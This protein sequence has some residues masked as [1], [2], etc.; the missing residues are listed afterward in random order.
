MC[1]APTRAPN[2]E[3]KIRSPMKKLFPLFSIA[4]LAAFATP[5]HARKTVKIDGSSSVF[6]ITEAV[7]EEF[8]KD[9]KG[10]VLV[11][12]G[13]SG[14]G[15]GFKKFCRG[16]ID[17]QDASRPIKI[18]EAAICKESNIS[19]IELPI[20]YDAITV[21]V[22]KKNTWLKDISMEELKKIWEPAAQGKVTT[23]NQVRKEWPKQPIRLYGA[24]S[25]SGTFDY[26][27][28]AV[29]GTARSSRSDYTSSE[30]DNTLVQGVAQDEYALAYIPFAY[31][32]HNTNKL[33][34][35]AVKDGKKDALTPSTQTIAD[36]SYTPF[37]RPIFIYVSTTALAKPEVEAFT[38]YYLK[39]V[40]TLSA[41]V[42][43]VALPA[44]VYAL[45]NKNYDARFQGSL[46]EGDNHTTSL[47]ALL[48]KKKSK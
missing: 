43:Y 19:Y 16:E 5:S 23:W 24:G 11:T 13:I 48:T 14:T 27:S 36:G 22:S 28:E 45:V 21:V 41:Q 26:F 39:N 2:I 47:E 10:K 12:V 8:Q 42:G 7:A 4:L 9:Q 31:Y 20:A 34:A 3:T 30:D 46:Y 25:D 32:K 29:T 6:P 1:W 15:G 35:V 18:S 17:V 37:S 38:K 44:N 33:T 40:P